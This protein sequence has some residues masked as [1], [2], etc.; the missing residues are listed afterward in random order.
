MCA[1]C[2]FRQLESVGRAVDVRLYSDRTKCNLLGKHTE[3]G[4]S[5]S[6]HWK[7]IAHKTSVDVEYCRG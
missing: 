1:V 7:F 5:T 2:F 6:G 4:L 3:R